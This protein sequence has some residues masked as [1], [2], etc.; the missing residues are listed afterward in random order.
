VQRSIG[1]RR[2]WNSRLEKGQD[3]EG[4]KGQKEVEYKEQKGAGY[5]GT[6]CGRRR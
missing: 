5:E 3:K 6:V 2:T 4:Y 1:W